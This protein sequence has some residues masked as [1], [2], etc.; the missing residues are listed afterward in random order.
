MN[1]KNFFHYVRK[2]NYGATVVEFAVILPLLIL[3]VFGIIEFSLIFY[4]KAIIT[5]SAREGARAGVVWGP[6]LDGKSYRLTKDEIEEI[7]G[8]YLGNH[9]ITFGTP[10][11]IV[12]SS[13]PCKGESTTDEI[14]VTI[15]YSHSFFVLP[16]GNINLSSQ[17]KMICESIAVE[18]ET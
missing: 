9:I 2:N 10:G 13:E 18:E 6:D 16:F 5:N 3:I 7:A 15:E 8:D 14:T 11:P 4:N 17:S 1:I 12:I